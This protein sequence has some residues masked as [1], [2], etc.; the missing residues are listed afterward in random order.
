MPR[1]SLIEALRDPAVWPAQAPS[2]TQVDVVETH[3]STVLLAGDLA[4]KIKKPVTL[5][6]LD[7]GTLEKRRIACEAELALN[8]RFAPD[9]YL[10]VAPIGGPEHD[11]PRIDGLPAREWGVLMRR[12]D[13]ARRADHLC[14]G[15]CLA[16]GHLVDFARRF[17]QLQAD[18]PVVAG[19]ARFGTP[20][21]VIAPA[22]ENFIE[23]AQLR[24][25]LVL[26][27]ALAAWTERTFMRLADTFAARRRD[28]CVRE[29]HG[30]LHLGNLVLHDGRLTAFDGIEFS[31][32]LR[33]IDV[34]S[35]IAFLWMDLQD[36]GRGDLAAR[37][38]DA[39]LTATGDFAA[40]AVL[41]F[42]AVYRAVV[43]AKVAAIRGAQHA[44]A[45]DGDEA[46]AYIALAA[47]IAGLPDR[48]DECAVSPP[49]CFAP[50]LVITCGLSG[51]GKTTQ[52]T[53]W[54]EACADAGGVRLRSDVERKRLYGL[55]ADA[56]SG[57]AIDGGIYTPDANARTYARLAVLAREAL[58]H[59]WAVVVDA[60]FLRRAERDAFRALARDAGVGFGILF[61]EATADELAQRIAAR[62]GDASEATFE[63]VQRQRA[64]F[65][66][67][68]DDEAGE[69]IA[70]AV[71]PPL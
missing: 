38:L 24:P 19:D 64:W 61:C 63:V 47:R 26:S 29:G 25:D 49:L 3:I 1:A 53:A 32:D 33:W 59:G 66:P 55:A 36:H 6:F 8:R 21:A 18:A 22:R 20:D 11:R 40:L 9:L 46:G 31:A 12:F 65:E 51:S 44:S 23:L 13:E 60:A 50:R 37:F 58:A 17:A 39:W 10:R 4:C 45:V 54:L 43:R 70:I 68:G 30:D 57:S 35:D 48:A 56:G 41:R 28:G 7:Y 27:E 14:R 15:G 42:Y 16:A 34:A 2:P 67:L 52:S 5:P 69:R 71:P 62:T